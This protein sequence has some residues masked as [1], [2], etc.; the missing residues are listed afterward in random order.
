[1]QLN[2]AKVKELIKEEFRNNKTWFAET[3]GVS[4]GY[5]CQVLKGTKKASSQKI[6]NAIIGYCKSNNLNFKDY[7]FF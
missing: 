7:I 1:M 3:I 6:C 4:K 2:T 5:L